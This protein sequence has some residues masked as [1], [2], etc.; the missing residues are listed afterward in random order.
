MIALWPYLIKNGNTITKI[1]TYLSGVKISL[2]QLQSEI[3][4]QQLKLGV[5]KPTTI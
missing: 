5:Q 2:I 3:S 4:L 1:V